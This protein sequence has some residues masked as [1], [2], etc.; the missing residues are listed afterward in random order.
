[1]KEVAPVSHVF[2]TRPP[3][4]CTESPILPNISRK[5]PNAISSGFAPG[6]WIMIRR[7]G[8]V[9]GLDGTVESPLSDCSAGRGARI[10]GEGLGR[11]GGTTDS[12]ARCSADFVHSLTSSKD[13]TAHLPGLHPCF[14]FLSQGSQS[15]SSDPMRQI[16]SSKGNPSIGP[17][18]CEHS[19]MLYHI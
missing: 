2:H 16:G 11:S 5:T 10:G 18:L 8:S 6:L 4:S 15:S 3:R 1:M 9:G 19:C 7:L 17:Y 14:A 13:A 12:G